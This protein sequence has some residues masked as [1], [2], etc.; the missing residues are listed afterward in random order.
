MTLILAYKSRGITRE[1]TILDAAGATI[2]PGAND[3][4]KAIVLRLGE[5]PKLTVTSAAPTSNGSS[6]T[7][8]ATCT[9]RLDNADL[10]TIDPGTYTLE[11]QLVDNA[12]AQEP[13]VV[14]RQVLV[15]ENS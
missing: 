8:G 5:T 1:I 14:Q 3:V 10:S 2:T 7:K 13:K 15:L 12:D 9:L 4:I 11:I 6:F